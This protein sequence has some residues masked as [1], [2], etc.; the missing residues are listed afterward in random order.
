MSHRASFL[1][2][3]TTF[4]SIEEYHIYTSCKDAFVRGGIRP[5]PGTSLSIVLADGSSTDCSMED[6]DEVGISC[7][8]GM[9]GRF[10]DCFSVHQNAVN[11]TEAAR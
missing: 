6:I 8:I 2:A 7:P 4:G 10:P 1:L 9:Y 3:N 5:S 11:N